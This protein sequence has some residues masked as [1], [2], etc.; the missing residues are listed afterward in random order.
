MSSPTIKYLVMVLCHNEIQI[1]KPFNTL[2]EAQA[3]AIEF[4]NIF[5]SLNGVAKFFNGSSIATIAHINEYYGS[6]IY[7]DFGDSVNIVIEEVV[8]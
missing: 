1:I 6:G 3:V 7:H 5:F 4:A 8:L 2:L